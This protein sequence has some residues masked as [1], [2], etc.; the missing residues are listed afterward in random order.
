MMGRRKL[1][2]GQSTMT[3]TFVF[4]FTAVAL[5]V[6]ACG[7]THYTRIR[8][9]LHVG[10]VDPNSIPF[11]SRRDEDPRSLPP[12]TLV[13]QA[14]LLEVTPERVCVRTNL[15]SLDEVNPERGIYESYRIALVTD[16]DGVEQ[17]EPQIQ[18]EAPQSQAYNGTIPQQIHAGYRQVCAAYS[19]SVCVSW[20]QEPIYRTIQVPHVWMVTNH[21]ASLC[22]A[23]G[24]FVTPATTRLALELDGSGPG[25]MTFEWQFDSAVQQT[26]VQA[27]ASN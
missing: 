16:R 5:L 3:R 23:N 12:G 6:S 8:H 17:S 13:D 26:A 9:P 24:G 11:Q 18:I 25:S 14:Q 15:W 27:Q 20:R 1:G 7:A 21:P 19:Q 4:T 2:R 10:Q 22:F